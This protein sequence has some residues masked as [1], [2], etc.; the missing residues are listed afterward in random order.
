MEIAGGDT[1]MLQVKVFNSR[2]SA[3]GN[4]T[5]GKAAGHLQGE[6]EFQRSTA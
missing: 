1:E 4:L 6:S 3:Y 5:A 2:Q